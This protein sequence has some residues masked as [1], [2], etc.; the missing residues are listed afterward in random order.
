MKQAMSGLSALGDD[1]LKRVLGVRPAALIQAFVLNDLA[2]TTI[3]DASG[4]G[5]PGVIASPTFGQP[6]MGDGRLSTSF[7]GLNSYINNY[8][9]SYAAQF[10]PLEHT[11]FAWVENLDWGGSTR[12]V[13]YQSASA[14]NRSYM[15]SSSGSFAFVHTAGGVAAGVGTPVYTTFPSDL[16]CIGMSVSKSNDRVRGYVGDQLIGEVNA[17]GVWAGALSA[18]GCSVGAGLTT[19]PPPNNAWKGR[20]C[21]W[22]VWNVELTTSEALMVG[23]Y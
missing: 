21:H 5:N 20:L 9:A 13:C 19:A 6:G 22:Y 12:R 3:A 2:G 16:V 14:S 15:Q 17:L 10:N 18:T 1:Y 7:D 23:A 11:L 4:K 8:S